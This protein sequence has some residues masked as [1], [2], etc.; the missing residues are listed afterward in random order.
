MSWVPVDALYP[1]VATNYGGS[2]RLTI[3]C[4]PQYS[5]A[6]YSVFVDGVYQGTIYIDYTCKADYIAQPQPGNSHCIIT[7]EYLGDDSEPDAGTMALMLADVQSEISYS[8]RIK[9]TW[10]DPDPTPTSPYND[11]SISNISLT[12]IIKGVNCANIHL[13]PCRAQLNYT[14]T[15]EYM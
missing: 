12:G 11:S 7:I 8:N 10:V 4:L 2:V 13:L 15:H 5:D 9:F 1:I 3:T 6:H 14:L